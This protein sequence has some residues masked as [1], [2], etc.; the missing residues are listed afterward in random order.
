MSGWLLI[1][2]KGEIARAYGSDFSDAI[3]DPS[4]TIAGFTTFL[5]ANQLSAVLDGNAVATPP[6]VRDS[7]SAYPKPFR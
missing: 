1:D 4:G 5:D 3:I 2:E 7:I 6:D